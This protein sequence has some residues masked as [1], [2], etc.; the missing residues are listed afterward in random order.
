MADVG[1]EERLRTVHLRKHL[2]TPAFLLD[3]ARVLHGIADVGGDEFEKRCVLGVVR[4]GRAYAGDEDPP[5]P[6][7]CPAGDRQNDRAYDLPVCRAARQRIR[8]PKILLS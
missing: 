2:Q 7:L 4:S 3:G 1:E 8:L 6:G 5:G